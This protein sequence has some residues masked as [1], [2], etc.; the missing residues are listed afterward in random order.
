MH[1]PETNQF[2]AFYIICGNMGWGIDMSRELKG[3]KR[4]GVWVKMKY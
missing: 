1:F 4:V 2:L 3:L